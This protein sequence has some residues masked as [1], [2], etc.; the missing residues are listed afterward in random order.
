MCVCVKELV[1]WKGDI[2]ISSMNMRRVR[3]ALLEYV[4]VGQHFLDPIVLHALIVQLIVFVITIKSRI[5]QVV[6]CLWMS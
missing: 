5:G 6:S 1:V 2:R 4:E 3:I